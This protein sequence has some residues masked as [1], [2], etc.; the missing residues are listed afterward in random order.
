MKQGVGG[1]FA[2]LASIFSLLGKLI[3]VIKHMPCTCNVIL[4]FCHRVHMV[5]KRPCM[6]KDTLKISLIWNKFVKNSWISS[7]AREV[8]F[9]RNVHVAKKLSGTN[10][11][12]WA[13]FCLT[14][15]LQTKLDQPVITSITSLH[16]H[17]S[18]AFLSQG[19]GAMTVCGIL[20]SAAD[21][22]FAINFT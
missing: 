18:H 8:E 6:K 12:I 3:Y 21:Y 1:T 13:L 9:S 5:S 20:F 7:R 22:P 11:S 16:L 10:L 19:G 14:A 17:M 2:A 15:T 4:S